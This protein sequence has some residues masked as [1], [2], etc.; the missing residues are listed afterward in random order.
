MKCM[1]LEELIIR[2][3]RHEDIPRVASFVQGI[4]PAFQKQWQDKYEDNLDD[5][6]IALLG[7]KDATLHVS[8]GSDS[9]WSGFGGPSRRPPS[10]FK[11]LLAKAQTKLTREERAEGYTIDSNGGKYKTVEFF[12]TNTTNHFLVEGTLLTEEEWNEW[13][14][15][16]ELVPAL[17]DPIS[18]FNE[19]YHRGLELNKPHL[20]IPTAHMIMETII[21]MFPISRIAYFA[22]KSPNFLHKVCHW[23]CEHSL[24]KWALMCESDAPVLMVP[25]DCAYKGRP[26]LS[27][28]MYKEFV[29]PEFQKYFEMAHKAGKI[30]IMHSD[31]VVEPYYNDLIEAGLDAHESLESVAG[32][33]LAD[34]KA[35]YGDRLALIGNIDSLH[36]FTL[37]IHRGSD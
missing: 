5:D 11:A 4:M 35:R 9:S 12:E 21:G 8:L 17:R 10:D 20:L 3:L 34:L 29:I 7:I 31:G 26:I 23:I 30:V 37:W 13:Y 18:E 33:N 28:T 1:D 36:S 27:P 19:S 22:R 24:Q 25:D 32:N 2:S 14:E 15:N 16:W 6:D